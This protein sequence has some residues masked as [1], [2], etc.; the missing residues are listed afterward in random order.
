MS[1]ILRRL[2]EDHANILRLLTILD[3]QIAVLQCAQR[4]DW[5]IVQGVIDYCLTYPDLHHHPLEDQILLRLREKA[6]EAAEPF[7]RLDAEHS[8]LSEAARR[9]AAAT[10]VVLQDSPMSRESYVELLRAFV[11][12]QREHVQKEESSFFPAAERVLDAADWQRLNERAVSFI[13]PLFADG[14]EE[15]FALLRRELAAWDTVDHWER[16]GN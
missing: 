9:M 4:P 3:R 5:D 10:R 8:A 7:S 1:N 2:R 15:R 6:P 11:A 14:S 12:A 16:E 13:D